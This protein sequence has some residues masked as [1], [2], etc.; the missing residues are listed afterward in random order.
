MSSVDVRKR[1]L[2]AAGPVFSEKG[3]EKATVREIC[4]K[5]DVNVASVNYYFGDKEQLYLDVI[6]LAKEMGVSRAPLP[7]WASDTLPEQKLRD[8][9]ITL[10]RRMLGT[11]E[12]SWSNHLIMREVLRPT[13]ACEHLIQELFRP[14]VNVADAILLEMLGEDVPAYRRMQCIFSIAAQCQFYRVSGGMVSL[15][16]G[17]EEQEIHYNTERLIEHILQFS[18][19]AIKNLKQEFDGS[20]MESSS[21]FHKI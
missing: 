7:E 10:V 6:C 19:A 14:F 17:Q 12:L 8:W 13:K 15:M 2:E 9:V 5:A 18:L 21:T 20:V 1:L 4:Q 16:L 3:F 11:G